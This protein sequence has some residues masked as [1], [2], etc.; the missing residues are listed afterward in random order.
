MI[1]K[2]WYL[3]KDYINKVDF[4]LTMC[5]RIHVSAL[6]YSAWTRG[7]KTS[8]LLLR[9]VTSRISNYGIAVD[10]YLS[11]EFKSCV[12]K[13]VILCNFPH[14]NTWKPNVLLCVR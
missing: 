11:A 6:F 5:V 3:Y 14:P 1:V 2:I 12:N 4:K 8:G 7:A 10:D 13:T 9:C